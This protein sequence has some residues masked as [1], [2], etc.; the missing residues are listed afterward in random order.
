MKSG[1]CFC[2]RVVGSQNKLR[3]IVMSTNLENRAKERQRK[4]ERRRQA[5]EAQRDNGRQRQR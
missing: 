4:S 3:L 1:N 5:R 2:I